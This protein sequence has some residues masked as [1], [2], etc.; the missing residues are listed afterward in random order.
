MVGFE[1]DGARW[2]AERRKA[3]LRS[4]PEIRQ[5]IR[6][7]PQTVWAIAGLIGLQYALA[8]GAAHLPIWAACALAWLVGV[9]VA[10]ALGVAVHE[11]AHD[12]VFFRPSENKWMSILTNM[13]LMFPA[14]IDFRGK[15]LQH[16]R[17]LGET[18]ADLQAPTPAEARFT[19]T[20]SWRKLLWLCVG[21]LF[22]HGSHPEPGA[23]PQRGWMAANILACV[24]TMP[25]IFA[26][27]PAA[28]WFLFLSAAW[29]FGP[30]PVGVRRYAEHVVLD[31]KQPTN[32]Y[33]GFWSRLAFRVGH[34]VEHHDFPGIPW[35]HLE[36]V[37]RTAR[38]FY[39][40]LKTIPSWSGLWWSFVWDTAHKVDRYAAASPA[41][42][43]REGTVLRPS[44]PTTPA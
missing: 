30:H 18:P 23:R 19:G 10:H 1:K 13:P 9:P 39:D 36:R 31:P 26:L 27:S 8:Y 24:T 16:H 28:F 14:A 34:H 42:S 22:F 38:P 43:M 40:S 4:Y 33:Y 44:R 21:P 11:C 15:H 32:S 2:H 25:L 12:L 37:R 35:L 41:R 6:P 29:A 17:Y 3:I 5:L 7:A 20:S